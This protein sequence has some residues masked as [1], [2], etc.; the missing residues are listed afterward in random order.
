MKDKFSFLK[1]TDM[2]S[3]I[4]S[5]KYL[6]RWFVLFVD[7][8]ICVVAYL[9]SSFL[10]SRFIS[11]AHD[12]R[13]WDVYERTGFILAVQMV[14]F[15]TFHTYSGVLRY[16]GYVDAAKLLLAVV[17]NVLVVLLLNI[18]VFQTQQV[19]LFYNIGLLFYAVTAFVLLFLLRLGTKTLYDFFK[20]GRA[21]V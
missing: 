9:I 20:I 19:Y 12:I 11:I 14:F 3:H 17:S 10:S 16:S 13:I 15:W 21:H 8:V 6:P 1:N 4:V 18:I 7:I 5:L 2:F